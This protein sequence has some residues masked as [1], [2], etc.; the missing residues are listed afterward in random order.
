MQIKARHNDLKSM[1]HSK[2]NLKRKVY[3]NIILLQEIWKTSN[4]KE[5]KKINKCKVSKRKEIIK[6]KEEINEWLK[7]V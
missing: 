3:N 5:L 4:L 1:K 7:S 2:C 6:I